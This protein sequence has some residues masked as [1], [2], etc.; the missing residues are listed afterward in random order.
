MCNVMRTLGESS[1]FHTDPHPGNLAV[2]AAVPGGRL[3]FYDLGQVRA[4]FLIRSS[5]VRSFIRSLA[6]FVRS[7]VRSLA[8]SL[9]RRSATR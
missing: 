9:A 5:F 3:I 1:F 6:S 4:P 2:D 7:F 8:R